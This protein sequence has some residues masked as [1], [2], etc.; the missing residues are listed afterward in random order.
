MLFKI[1]G[2]CTDCE[3]AIIPAIKNKFPNAQLKMELENQDKILHIHGLPEDSE[4]AAKIEN[5]IKEVGFEG[6][7]LTRGLENK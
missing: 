1:K 2:Q 3:A 5:A 4:H 6:A 7:W